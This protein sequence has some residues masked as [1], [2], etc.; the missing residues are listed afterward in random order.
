[1]QKMLIKISN[2]CLIDKGFVIH[3]FMKSEDFSVTYG[4]IL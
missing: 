4:S 2:N 1:M 3:V